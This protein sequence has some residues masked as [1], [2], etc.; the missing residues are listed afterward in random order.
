M[1]EGWP[2]HQENVPVPLKGAAGVVGSTS[3]D[4]W[5]EPTT[6]AAPAKEA[7]RHFLYGAAT[8]PWP[9]LAKEG[10]SHS[11]KRFRT[12]CPETNLWVT[13]RELIGNLYVCPRIMAS[14]NSR[15]H[16][17]WCS[18]VEG[19][20]GPQGRIEAR[21]QQEYFGQSG[22]A[23]VAVRRLR[24]EEELK[25]TVERMWSRRLIGISLGTLQA[26]SRAEQNSLFL[27]V[28]LA[29]EGF[30][31]LLRDRLLIVRPGTLARAREYGFTSRQ[32]TSPVELATA[33]YRDSVKLKVPAGFQLDEL[34][35]PTNVES[36]YGTLQ[37]LWK[38]ENA[39]ILF[40][41]TLEIRNAV[42]PADE[43][44]DVR[45][46]FDKV[47]AALTAPVILVKR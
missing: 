1:K 46:F 40:E 45:A 11:R 16:A 2:R 12:R 44:A 9:I 8:P 41:Q 43:Y 28:S 36:P 27:D 14:S 25:R 47:R 6:P 18:V 30:G 32:R 34:P 42:V 15:C 13:I 24:G 3:D 5:L 20:I 39:E 21:L 33:L 37:A 26:A 17:L 38:V 10:N 22:S 35:P 31:E 4:R 7:S 29:A 19:V 23:L